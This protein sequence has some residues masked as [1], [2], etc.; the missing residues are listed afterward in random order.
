MALPTTGAIS[1]LDLKNEFGDTNPVRMSEFYRNG[2]L[3]PN[4]P[5]NGGVPTS[6][7]ISLADLRGAVNE[8]VYTFTS[9]E[10]DVDIQ[11]KFSGPVWSSPVPKR[12]IIPS[13]ITIFATNSSR[14]A[15]SVPSGG[16]GPLVIENRGEIQGAG[17]AAGTTG[18]GGTGGR[19]MTINRAVSI[20]NTGA[21]RGG[22]GGGGRGRDGTRGTCPLPPENCSTNPGAGGFC[23]A[24]GCP[25]G[26][27]AGSRCSP[28]GGPCRI[29]CVAVC[30]CCSRPPRPS[31]PAAGSGGA[32]GKG[33]GASNTVTSGQAG[34]DVNNSCGTTD[35]GPGG[36]GGGW[37]SAGSRGRDSA[38]NVN[39]S[40]GGAGGFAVVGASRVTW[41]GPRGTTPGGT[42]G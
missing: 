38:G 9:S 13:G 29:F 42:S 6:G 15:I 1:L 17:G 19:A 7:T 41:I 2:G 30:T 10:T 23:S 16:A 27:R 40:P 28:S 31:A 4:A 33:R 22:G 3:V 24:P 26:C 8:I 5:S 36:N 20:Q 39:G 18:N 25:G 11:G 21:I 14:S 12:V 32:G 34:Q 35:G 37:G